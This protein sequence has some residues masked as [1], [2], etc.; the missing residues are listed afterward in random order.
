MLEEA[1][2]AERTGISDE[3]VRLIVREEVQRALGRDP[4]R[5]KA[6]II[7]SK[8]TLDMAYPPLNLGLAAS[9]MEVSIFFALYGMNIIHKDFERKL[10][11]SPVANPAMPMPLPLPDLLCAMPG[12]IPF[13]TRMMQSR[14]KKHGMAPIGELLHESRELGVRL[15]GCETTLQFMGYRKEDFV[16]GVEFA[17]GVSVLSQARQAHLNLFI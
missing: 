15:I 16:E 1:R 9:G 8:G 11:V 5:N 7:A 12:M 17:G 3:E 13:A 4:A 6:A 2:L 10:R 14:F